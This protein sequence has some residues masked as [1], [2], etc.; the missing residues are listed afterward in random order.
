M[1]SPAMEA[2]LERTMPKKTLTLTDRQMN[3]LRDEFSQALQTKEYELE[4]DL[5]NGDSYPEQEEVVQDMQA[6]LKA[7]DAS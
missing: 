5:E 1:D 4:E 6:I 2:G 7:I 3:I